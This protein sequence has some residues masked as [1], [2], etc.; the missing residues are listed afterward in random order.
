MRCLYTGI[1]AI[2]AAMS[3]APSLL[4]AQAK[5]SAAERELFD[6]ANRER[7]ARGVA[8]L[9]WDSQ[10]AEAARLHALRMAQQNAISHQF[11]GEPDFSTRLHDAGAHFSSAAEN[12][13]E[14]PTP[15]MVHDGWMRSPGHRENLLDPEMSSLGV[16]VVERGGQLFAVQDFDKS[17]AELSLADQQG[18][19][20]AELK[21]QGLRV[22]DGAAAAHRAC[23]SNQLDAAGHRAVF[24]FR[25]STEDLGKLPDALERQ[26]RTGRYGEAA[27]AACPASNDANYST[28][29]LAVLLY[30]P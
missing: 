7:T 10:L 4:R 16:G 3:F 28:Y 25:Y 23:A 24:V 27:V 5:A 22:Q 30:E 17:L 15:G 14:G 19:V 13:A 29:D 6:D 8:P 12:V 11:P 1:V 9:R 26:I 18:E 20:A 21:K 2:A